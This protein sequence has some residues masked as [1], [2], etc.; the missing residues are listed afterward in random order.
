[1]PLCW[2]VRAWDWWRSIVSLQKLGWLSLHTKCNGPGKWSRWWCG[3]LRFTSYITPPTHTC[4]LS[5]ISQRTETPFVQPG[6]PLAV[7]LLGFHWETGC[8]S[9]DTDF[10]T[11]ICFHVPSDSVIGWRVLR[12]SHPLLVTGAGHLVTNWSAEWQCLVA[13]KTLN[14]QIKS[15]DPERRLAIKRR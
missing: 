14:L 5:T 4:H 7:G 3:S 15:F 6:L 8:F 9:A 2:E 10:D 13:P 12:K 1:M 11:L